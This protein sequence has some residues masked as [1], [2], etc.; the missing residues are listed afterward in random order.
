MSNLTSIHVFMDTLVSFSSSSSSS[1]TH[2]PQVQY[3]VGSHLKQ[4][5]VTML[6]VNRRPS[7]VQ[8]PVRLVSWTLVICLHG[9][10]VA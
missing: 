10:L 1:Y 6:F 8:T 5:V 9:V 2:T 7:F 4:P 3:H